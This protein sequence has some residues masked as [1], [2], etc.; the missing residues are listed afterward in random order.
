[1]G[2]EMSAEAIAAAYEVLRQN[3]IRRAEE[4]RNEP[5][6]ESRLALIQRHKIPAREGLAAVCVD[7]AR[8][9]PYHDSLARHGL[10]HIDFW[11]GK[12]HEP[13][14]AMVFGAAQEMRDGQLAQKCLGAFGKLLEGD[15][16]NVKAVLAGLEHLSG[17]GKWAKGGGGVG[18]NNGGAQ[19]V[20]NIQLLHAP[21]AERVA[22]GCENGARNEPIAEVIEIKGE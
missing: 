21:K 16:P 15:T 12:L 17:D 14:V 6:G 9:V 4:K 5:G 19:I 10:S 7:V 18:H 2:A 8:G 1:M 22:I 11:G 20:Y 13:A 3:A